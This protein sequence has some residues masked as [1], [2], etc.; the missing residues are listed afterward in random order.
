M[1]SFEPPPAL[2]FV[3]F[4]R[5]IPTSTDGDRPA[6]Q[7]QHATKITTRVRCAGQRLP[8]VPRHPCE[9]VGLYYSH[10]WSPGLLRRTR[11]KRRRRLAA[12]GHAAARHPT[13]NAVRPVHLKRRRVR[14]RRAPPRQ[15]VRLSRGRCSG[16]LYSIAPH[17]V[18]NKCHSRNCFQ[19]V[20]PCSRCAPTEV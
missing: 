8:Y 5:R 6:L 12:G 2:L 4:G 11:S 13:R 19:M 20:R 14:L 3:Q 9:G 15:F 17:A 18:P 7:R 16:M 10:L 1:E